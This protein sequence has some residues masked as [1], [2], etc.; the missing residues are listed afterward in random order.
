MKK[1]LLIL[2][3]I[4]SL[5]LCGCQKQPPA[6]TDPV[7]TTPAQQG[8]TTQ[9][10]QTVQTLKVHFLDVGQADCALIQCGDQFALIDGGNYVDGYTVVNYLREL[11][12]TELALMV[13]THPHEDHIG[14]LPIVLQAFDVKEVW[15]SALPYRNDTVTNFTD[16]VASEGLTLRQ[17]EPGTVFPLGGATITMLG[18]VRTDYEDVNDLSLVLMVEFES[19]RFL[20]TGDMELA[21]ETDLLDSGADVKADVLKVG[22]H[23]S[24]SSTGYRFLR[25]VDPKYAV[26]S[27]GAYNEYGHPHDEPMSRLRDAEVIVHR[28]DRQYTIVATSDGENIVF[29]WQNPYAQPG[30]PALEDTSW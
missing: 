27:V 10:V 25:E 11:G 12:V 29:H 4:L 13:G 9:P 16:A 5:V 7:P 6:H 2:L 21:G 3:L 18:P 24:Y 26:I 15:T 30:I 20:F 23:G 1:Q 17:P 8:Q 14:S 28:T 19:T 22:H